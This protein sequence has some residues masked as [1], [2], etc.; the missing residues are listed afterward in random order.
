MPLLHHLWSI[1][2]HL[3]SQALDFYDRH[4]RI[5]DWIGLRLLVG[6]CQWWHGRKRS[7]LR[8]KSRKRR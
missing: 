3:W 2:S 1:A 6:I 7:K 4:S 5:A 8:R